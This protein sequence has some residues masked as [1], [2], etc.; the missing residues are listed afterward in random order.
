MHFEGRA[1]HIFSMPKANVQLSVMSDS[2][3]PHGL[4]VAHQAPLS[5]GLPRQEYWSGL[6]F[7]FPGNLPNPGT[8]PKSLASPALV[9]RLFTTSAIWESLISY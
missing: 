8:E 5:M 9:G 2:L 4:Y 3:H 6:P 7:S 1:V